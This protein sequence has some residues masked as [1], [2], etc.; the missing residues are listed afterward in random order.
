M[1]MKNDKLYPLFFVPVYKD[2]LWGGTRIKKEFNRSISNS[3]VAESWEISC[4]EHGL[5]MIENGPLKGVSLQSVFQSHKNQLMGR[6]SHLKRF[7]LLIKLIDA[8]ENLSIQVHPFSGAESKTECWYFLDSH[9]DSKIFA[10]L[11][12]T[13]TKEKIDAK[14]PN[15][16]ILDIMHHVP[17][18]KDTLAFIPGGSLHAI[19]KGCFI[20][21][22]QQNSDTTYRVYDWGRGRECHIDQAKSVLN[23]QV[24][25]S[26]IQSPKVIKKCSDYTCEELLKT[27][28]F[29]VER[30]SIYKKMRWDKLKN[31]CEFLFCISGE[32]SFVPKGR[33]CLLP[34][35]CPTPLVDTLNST[36]IR[37]YLP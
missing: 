37:A 9:Q 10:G 24:S 12:Q 31:Q 22:I 20:L 35:D 26:P 27:P 2:Y 21:E 11:N 29:C 4:H 32:N 7:P 34:A 28:Y 8:S 1:N 16:E 17:A 25:N 6:H 14:L 13:L 3:P 19:G 15:K 30:W 23:Y 33:S 36:F 5:S 18:C